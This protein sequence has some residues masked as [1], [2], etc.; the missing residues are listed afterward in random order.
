MA[1]LEVEPKPKRPLWIWILIALI[2]FLLAAM[3]FR[4]CDAERSDAQRA[5]MADS[6][7]IIGSTSPDW[8]NI[9]FDIATSPNADI[10]DSEIQTRINNN[11][12]I[13][14][15]GE[16]ILFSTDSSE[17]SANGQVK[18]KMI[19][20]VLNKKFKGAIIAVFGSTDSTG[21]A[22][23]NKQF[24]AQRAESVKKWLILHGGIP[25]ENVS[26]QS[27]GEKE[28]VA[29]NDTKEG[30]KQNRNVSIVVFPKK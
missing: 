26:V 13:Y 3:L 24:G 18:I 25:V 23:E 21:P 17:F 20:D 22:D 29:S 4:K 12:T 7:T 15:L 2:L 14:T 6:T 28:P 10:A 19:S 30:R 27:L 1:H 11:Y 5:A 16:N 8:K 9:D